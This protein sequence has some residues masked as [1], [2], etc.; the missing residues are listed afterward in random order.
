[1]NTAL[2]IP[3]TSFCKNRD[4]LISADDNRPHSFSDPTRRD[5]AFT[6][7]TERAPHLLSRS[8]KPFAFKRKEGKKTGGHGT[9]TSKPSQAIILANPKADLI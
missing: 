3:R 6:N 4:I 1:M 5:A 8:P 9:E 2:L 7:P